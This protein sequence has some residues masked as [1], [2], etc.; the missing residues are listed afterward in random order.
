MTRKIILTQG[1]P[2]SGK[3]TWAIRWRDEQPGRVRVNRDDVREMLFGRWTGLREDE[4]LVTLIVDYARRQA[5]MQDRQVVADDMWLNPEHIEKTRQLAADC[6]ADLSIKRF[7]TSVAECIRR[8]RRRSRSV[9]ENVIR[10]LHAR[11]RT[12]A[13][14]TADE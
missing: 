14:E 5:L 9:G 1:I 2:G 3:T 8:D 11:F 12:I 7:T 10:Q 4:E 6:E 13:K